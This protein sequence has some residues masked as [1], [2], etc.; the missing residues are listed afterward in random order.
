MT[1]RCL[2][3]LRRQTFHSNND[4][5][6]ADL[7]P[8]A[9]CSACSRWSIVSAGYWVFYSG[10]RMISWFSQFYCCH[11]EAWLPPSFNCLQIVEK[12][13]TRSRQAAECAAQDLAHVV[14]C[15]TIQLIRNQVATGR[16]PATIPASDDSPSCI[17]SFV[18]NRMASTVRYRFTAD[19][20]RIPCCRNTASSPSRRRF[21]PW[22]Q[23]KII[24]IRRR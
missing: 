10:H 12:L 24:E 15:Q 18:V 20:E 22:T 14:G 9:V 6:N 19:A 17:T 8:L 3:Q 23:F 21:A 11:R 2:G 7:Y 4:N 13:T 1:E 16:R 5:T